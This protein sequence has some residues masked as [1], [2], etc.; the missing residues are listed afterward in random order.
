MAC[1]L[2]ACPTAAFERVYTTLLSGESTATLS[3]GA[4]VLSSDR[5][6]LRFAK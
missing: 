5:G 3:A 6:Q 4:L 1:T 2:A